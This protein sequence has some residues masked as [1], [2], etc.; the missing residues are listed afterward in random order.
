MESKNILLDSL[1][2]F[3]S[4]KSGSCKNAF[5]ENWFTK[6]GKT[7]NFIF[8]QNLFVTNIQFRELIDLIQL[9]VWKDKIQPQVNFMNT[10]DFINLTSNIIESFIDEKELN[11]I[12][13]NNANIKVRQ[14][15]DEKLKLVCDNYISLFENTVIIDAYYTS[16]IVS[17]PSCLK[18]KISQVCYQSGY[19]HSCGENIYTRNMDK[20]KYD[21]FV[22][23]LVAY[24]SEYCEPLNFIM[25]THEDF[26]IK[27]KLYINDFQKN[28]LDEIKFYLEKFYMQDISLL[29]VSAKLKEEKKLKGKIKIV[30]K[31]E[32]KKNNTSE[33]I[34]LIIDRSI[35]KD[36]KY[37]GNK[38]YYICYKQ[39]FINENPFHIFDENKPGWIN[40]VTIPHTLVGAM[41]NIGRCGCTNREQEIKILDP[42]VGSGTTFLESLKYSDIRFKGGDISKIAQEVSRINMLFF[43]ADLEVIESLASFVLDYIYRIDSGQYH[44]ILKD[45]NASEDQ[46]NKKY[47]EIMLEIQNTLIDLK[48]SFSVEESQFSNNYY[49]LVKSLEKNIKR[50]FEDENDILNTPEYINLISSIWILTTWKAYKRNEY[51]YKYNKENFDLIDSTIDELSSLYYRI[52]S[53]IH[54][55]RRSLEVLNVK[56]KVVTYFGKYTKGCSLDFQYLYKSKEDNLKSIRSEIDVVDFLKLF[57]DDKIDLIIT[58]PP[59]GFNTIEEKQTF[60]KLYI[61][62][63]RAMVKCMK[64]GG[65]IIMCLPACSY[66]GKTVNIFAQKEIVSQQFSIAAREN[67][68]YVVEKK[69]Q[70]PEPKQLYQFPF[71]WDSEKALRRDIIR[72]QFFCEK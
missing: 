20:A 44:K 43:S 13:V 37:P 3:C 49:I 5:F 32:A 38:K 4:N 35:G 48:E 59:Y 14:S 18:L 42:F 47:R 7:Y 51:I 28:G 70:L 71:Y 68:M 53:Y 54:L 52:N 15:V 57:E 64:N 23:K 58:D 55:R 56:N 61:S 30:K 40:Q 27:N 69:E 24:L 17:L 11:T 65:Q 26:P 63:I 25:Y 45:L 22:E 9:N 6:Y 12:R 1:R 21:N 50:K 16:C 41:L 33:C 67:N 72:F 36:L 46:N 10:N 2:L 29:E 39:L 34:W 62:F 8:K 60:S 19:I 31:E 66:S